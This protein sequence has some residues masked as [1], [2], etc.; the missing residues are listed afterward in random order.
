M[1]EQTAGRRD[2]DRWIRVMET[3]FDEGKCGYRD[4]AQGPGREEAWLGL[5][6]LQEC[7]EDCE[8]LFIGGST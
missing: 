7:L 8:A 6:I 5:L 4:F 1:V 3:S 2:A